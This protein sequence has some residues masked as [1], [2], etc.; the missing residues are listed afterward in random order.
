MNSWL[1]AEKHDV[2]W[3]KTVNVCSSPAKSLKFKAIESEE[4]VDGGKRD[5]ARRCPSST[6]TTTTQNKR[7]WVAAAAAAACV[8]WFV[9]APP[10]FVVVSCSLGV[11]LSFFFLPMWD[12]KIGEKGTIKRVGQKQKLPPLSWPRKTS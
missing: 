10:V 9:R 6:I 12:E 1:N 3:V 4:L 5:E 7:V 2:F 11:F 8:C